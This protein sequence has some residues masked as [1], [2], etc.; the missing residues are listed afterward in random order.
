MFSYGNY[1]YGLRG[2]GAYVDYG[3]LNLTDASPA[4]SFTEPLSLTEVKA[5]LN[6]EESSPADDTDDVMLEAMIPA[7]RELAEI[8]QGRD[9]VRKQWDLSLDYWR[10]YQIEL[11]DPL[12]SVDLVRYRDSSGNYTTLTA[13]TDYIVD[14][15][16]HPGVVM[17]AYSKSWPS[18]TGWPS[19]A[20]LI[21][22]TSGKMASDPFWADAGS[23]LK[24]GM[25]YLISGWYENRLPA[26]FGKLEEIP[27]SISSCLGYGAR[28][29]VR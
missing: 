6:I 3:S 19:S 23:R 24:V 13:D 14:A 12:V 9:L 4:Q 28:R 25:R 2:Y 15:S 5:F 22:F 26:V 1:A 18:F 11:R 16:K 7:A 17:P 8:F 10:A 29:S 20:V 27:F 21:R